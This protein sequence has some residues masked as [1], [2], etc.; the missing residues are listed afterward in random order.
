MEGDKKLGLVK[1]NSS[2][3]LHSCVITW[4]MLTL[5]FSIQTEPANREGTALYTGNTTHNTLYT[6]VYQTLKT[7]HGINFYSNEYLLLQY[8]YWLN[9]FSF[10]I[11]VE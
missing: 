7:I 11:I 1:I 4:S 10:Q 6:L 9:E 5:D 8:K 3:K 2:C